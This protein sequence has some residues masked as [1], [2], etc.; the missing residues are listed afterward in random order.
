[1]MDAKHVM[2][3]KVIDGKG[4]NLL[5]GK[6]DYQG[7]GCDKCAAN[8]SSI[9]GKHLCEALGATCT[10]RRQSYWVKG[11]PVK[12]YAGR[13]FERNGDYEYNITVFFKLQGKQSPEK[14]LNDW[15]KNQY[16]G[17]KRAEG[18]GWYFNGD[19]VYVEAYGFHE[20]SENTYNEMTKLGY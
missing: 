19:E 20:I 10:S 3:I 9:K 7:S 12:Y 11:K 18:D 5:Y 13:L 8:G 6:E 14:H 15:A 16:S 17:S 2:E 1:M 4:Y